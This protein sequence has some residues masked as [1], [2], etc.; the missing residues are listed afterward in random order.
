MKILYTRISSL[1]IGL[2]KESNNGKNPA[3]FYTITWS[4]Y[5]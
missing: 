5:D 4:L 1:Y 3:H 2:L